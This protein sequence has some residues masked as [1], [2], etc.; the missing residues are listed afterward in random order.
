[1]GQEQD[2]TVYKLLTVIYII[3]LNVRGSTCKTPDPNFVLIVADDLGYGDLGCF[4]NTTIRTPHLDRLAA[5]GV[6]LTHNV[7]AASMCTPSRAAFLTGRYPIRSGM[8]A[9]HF[10]RA[11]P[12][13]AAAGGLPT[14]EIT[15]AE[16]T[17]KAGYRTAYLGK[18][19][20]GWSVDRSN[21]HHPHPLNQGFDY[22]Y[23][24]PLSNI[25][26]FGESGGRI[27]VSNLP[28]LPFQI[29]LTFMLVL[30]STICLIRVRYLPMYLGVLLIF[31]TGLVCGYLVFPHV[32]H[33]AV[34]FLHVQVLIDKL[35]NSFM[36]RNYDIVEQPIHLPSVTRKLVKESEEFLQARHTDHAP[37]LLLV[38]WLH[39]HTALA[40]APEFRGQSAHGPYGDAVEEMDWGVGQ[41]MEMLERLG[42]ADNTLVYFASDHGGAQMAKDFMGR[43]VGGF[44]GPFSG[45]KGDGSTEGSFRV[46][47]IVRWPGHVPAGVVVREPV[48]LMDVLP[49]VAELLNVSD[50]T[51]GHVMDGVSMV[52]LLRGEERVSP[53]EFLFHYCGD[54]VH[55]V[56]YRPR[57]G[58]KMWKLMFREPDP[59]TKIL[60]YLCNEA[61]HLDPPT[62]YDLSADPTASSPVPAGE[63]SQVVSAILK[64]VRQHQDSVQ[65][66]PSQLAWW[67]VIWQPWNQP[68]CNFPKCACEDEKFKGLFT[69]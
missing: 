48:S 52:P 26:D 32:Q 29:L 55:A 16:V 27:L 64:A 63:H 22:F 61:I 30:V 1:M 41:L 47:G 3:I 49:T 31:L 15:I 54:S 13:T 62:L 68:C 45:G 18:W 9:P 65:E 14:S 33:E 21:P 19:H 10:M 17:K 59:N 46:P 34:E 24:V 20:Q 58:T 12:L 28:H 69:D 25:P 8:V 35:L 67:R 40:T 44:N 23:G 5:E 36:F 38:S 57:S 51:S 42:M 53:H 37:F 50:V 6:K 4:G 43:V 39:V 11:Y 7:A 66:V 2:Q 60:V 56:T